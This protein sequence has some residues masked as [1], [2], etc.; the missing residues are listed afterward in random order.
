MLI[1][2]G[3][4]VRCPWR[5]YGDDTNLTGVVLSVARGTVRVRWNADGDVTPAGDESLF[6]PAMA[7][8]LDI[9]EGQS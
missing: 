7:A 6:P 3:M 5:E 8:A 1:K 9:V 2:R 4:T